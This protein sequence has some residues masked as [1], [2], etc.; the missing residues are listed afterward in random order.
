MFGPLLVDFMLS[1]SFSIKNNGHAHVIN[2]FRFNGAFDY[3]KK[4]QCVL[5]LLAEIN[6]GF[7]LRFVCQQIR[8]RSQQHDHHHH[9]DQRRGRH[10]HR[11]SSV[12]RFFSFIFCSADFCLELPTFS[13]HTQPHIRLYG[14][15]HTWLARRYNKSRVCAQ[16]LCLASCLMIRLCYNLYANRLPNW[17]VHGGAWNDISQYRIKKID[18]PLTN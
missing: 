14:C 17:N 15:I 12:C 16:L 8:I 2:E 18:F 5:H 4:L 10:P 6:F 1:F 13:K 11:C 7:C 9:H 3:A